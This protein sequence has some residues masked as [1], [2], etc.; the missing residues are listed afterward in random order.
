VTDS[1]TTQERVALANASDTP[2]DVTVTRDNDSHETT[3]L[4]GER[5][6]YDSKEDTKTR[7]SGSWPEAADEHVRTL[8]DSAEEERQKIEDERAIKRNRNRML[9]LA[10]VL[11]MELIV[12]TLY[13]WGMLP[14]IC[15][16]YEVLAITAPDI[17][18]TLYAYLRRY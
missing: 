18:L 13:G 12:P 8:I 9:I 6:N 5:V 3:H 1:T 11:L 10:V 14:A 4:D 15:I 17:A 16:K 2:T 7:V